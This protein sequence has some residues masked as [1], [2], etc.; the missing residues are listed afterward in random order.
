MRDFTIVLAGDTSLGDWYL[1]RADG[2]ILDRL[3]RDPM[4][5]FAGVAPLVAQ[6]DLFIANL[7]TVLYDNPTGPLDGIKNYLGWD[8]PSRTLDVLKRL[9]VDAVTLAN[10]HTMD[11]GARV[12]AATVSQL[13]RG[14]ILHFGAGRDL[15]CASTPLAWTARVPGGEKRIHVIGGLKNSSILREKYGFFATRNTWGTRP[16]ATR[17][18]TSQIRS[19]RSVDPDALIVLFPHWGQNYQWAS[20]HMRSTARAYIEAGADLIVGHGAHMLQE[21]AAYDSGS[22]VFSLG[23]FVFNSRGRYAAHHAPPYSAV[24]RLSLSLGPAGWDASLRL[25]LILSDNVKTGYRPRPVQADQAATAFEALR[26]HSYDP[27][28]FSRQYELDQDTLGWHIVQRA[29][30]SARFLPP[31][32]SARS[33]AGTTSGLTLMAVPTVE[34]NATPLTQPI[35]KFPRGAERYGEGS[36]HRCLANALRA[37]GIKCEEGSTVIRGSSRPAITFALS[38]IQYVI[39]AARIFEADP[40]GVPRRRIDAGPAKLVKRKDVVSSILRAGGFPVPEGAVF[41]KR[42]RRHAT[43]Y[44][45]ALRTIRPNGFCVKPPDGGLGRHVYV[46]ITDRARFESAFDAVATDYDEVLVEES[47]IGEVHRFLCVG[48]RVSAVRVGR[49]MNVEG[50]GKRSIRELVDLKNQA[51]SSNPIHRYYPVLLEEPQVRLLRARGYAPESIPPA[52]EIVSLG[53]SSN[54]HA[55]A[56][57]IDRTDVVHPTY[58]ERVA[59]A[60]A[61]IPNLLVCGADVMI[62]DYQVAAAAENYRI[63]ELNSGPGI[64][65][66][67]FPW[68]G[69][70]RDVAGDIVDMLETRRP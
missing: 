31:P 40:D 51:R 34:D 30:L 17:Q 25:Y 68:S 27:D 26:Q 19:I 18:L 24:G 2:P 39:S 66:H 8:S 5:F 50:D 9:G 37:R 15:T 14:G 69:E 49:P 12:L 52:G 47:L 45:D 64:G 53:H 1:Q 42:R 48:D 54:L 6:R 56:D 21:V 3:H 46:G 58:R 65:S 4:A 36:T 22:V 23:N 61:M 20:E 16:L 70:P 28:G 32:A 41:H 10:N 55:G 29:P 7:E 44:F 67:H 60:V 33:R 62:S 43:L 63:I 57:V 13:E 11:F 59:A 38:G 35:R